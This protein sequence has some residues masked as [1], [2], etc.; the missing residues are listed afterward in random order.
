MQKI[1]FA[2]NY[3]TVKPSRIINKDSK[4]SVEEFFLTM[5]IIFNDLKDLT[6]FTIL[7]ENQFENIDLSKASV[8]TGE[9]NGIIGHLQRLI[10]S[11]LHEFVKFL[12][13][14]K[15]LLEMDEFTIL[16]NKLNNEQ[17]RI[18]DQ[19]IDISTKGDTK[20]L[21]D[22]F[23]KILL[24]IRNNISSHYYQSGDQLRK[25]YIDRFFNSK[26]DFGNENA[27]YFLNG[28]MS[29]SRIFYSDAAAQGLYNN[30]VGEKMSAKVF[31]DGLNN[32]FTKVNFAILAI[33]K[34]YIKNLPQ[35]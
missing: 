19:L 26:K 13:E 24:R 10:I 2:P 5:G 21:T 14:N 25:G 6:F 29:K 32:L 7:V 11:T 12:S 1:K 4:D 17:K 3:R 9:Y 28:T 30:L 34:V 15:K 35:K 18:W 31:N 33:M 22:D 23:L 8:E 27:C 16:Y 20:D